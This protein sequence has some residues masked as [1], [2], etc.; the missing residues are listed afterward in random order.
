MLI[1]VN[2]SY[3]EGMAFSLLIMNILVPTIDSLVR[4]VTSRKTWLKYS[5]ITSFLVISCLL[6]VVIAKNI[7][8][9]EGTAY[10]NSESNIVL[11]GD[12]YE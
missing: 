1:R 11:R 2:S 12:T 6:N 8:F 7:T 4:G 3:P 9:N 10:V 5:L